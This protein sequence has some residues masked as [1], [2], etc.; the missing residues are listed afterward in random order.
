MK[1]FLEVV[2]FT[3]KEINQQLEDGF[4]VCDNSIGEMNVA[5]TQA[6]KDFDSL[7]DNPTVK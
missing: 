3:L 7:L 2:N 4:T 6:I 1:D 5:K